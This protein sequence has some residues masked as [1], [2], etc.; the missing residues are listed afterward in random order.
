MDLP[1]KTIYIC[2]KDEAHTC[3]E[4]CDKYKQSYDKCIL[5]ITYKRRFALSLQ[6]YN[7]RKYATD[8]QRN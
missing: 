7:S 6:R 5:S 1:S 8:I 4:P 2:T 3:T